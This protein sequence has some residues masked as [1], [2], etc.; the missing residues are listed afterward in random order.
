MQ[1]QQQWFTPVMP[2]PSEYK[3]NFFS[4]LFKFDEFATWER[5][6]SKFL[7]SLFVVDVMNVPPNVHPRQYYPEAMVQP[8]PQ[9]M[10]KSVRYYWSNYDWIWEPEK[11]TFN[12]CNRWWENINCLRYISDY[13][14]LWGH[15]CEITYEGNGW[16][17]FVWLKN[18]S[19]EHL[20]NYN[21]YLSSSGSQVWVS[22]VKIMYLFCTNQSQNLVFS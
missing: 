14:F 17:K 19:R 13:T 16:R 6:F 22:Y 15:F 20:Q 2:Q 5:L 7:T 10:D 9:S 12:Y 3:V 18:S 11:L 21:S 4:L 8:I 1:P